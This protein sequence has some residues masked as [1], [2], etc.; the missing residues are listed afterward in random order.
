MRSEGDIVSANE[1][2]PATSEKNIVTLRV[3][4]PSDGSLLDVTIFSIT[5]GAR[6]KAKLLRKNLLSLS[7]TASRKPIA[8]KSASK[9]A[10]SDSRRG[11]TNVC[12][13]AATAATVQAAASTRK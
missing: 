5:A 9:P 8:T 4:P 13:K 10:K 2:K 6:Y 12:S 3:S 7:V 11:S 1:E